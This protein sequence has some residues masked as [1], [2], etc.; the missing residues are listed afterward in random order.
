M[1]L[2]RREGNLAYIWRCIWWYSKYIHDNH[3]KAKGTGNWRG[4]WF[5][6]EQAFGILCFISFQENALQHLGRQRRRWY[7]LAAVTP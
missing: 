6:Q 1:N 7:R 2:G 5:F 3:Y 4:F